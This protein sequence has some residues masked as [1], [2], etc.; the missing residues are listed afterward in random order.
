MTT[1]RRLSALTVAFAVAAGGDRVEL[2][3][4]PFLFGPGELG[5]WEYAASETAGILQIRTAQEV[6]AEFRCSEIQDEEILTAQA[7]ATVGPLSVYLSSG[8][9]EGARRWADDLLDEP[10]GKPVESV[11]LYHNATSEGDL[12]AAMFEGKNSDVESIAAR[13]SDRPGI[14]IPTLGFADGW[15][16]FVDHCIGIFER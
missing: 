3:H 2:P 6:R 16:Q 14:A 9:A 13:I 11:T 12:V 7:W 4:D 8:D 15:A 5:V 1:P 10:F